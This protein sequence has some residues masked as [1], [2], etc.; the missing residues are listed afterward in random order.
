MKKTISLLMALLMVLSLLPTAWAANVDDMSSTAEVTQQEE[1]IPQ[2]DEQLPENEDIVPRTETPVIAPE[3]METEG[4]DDGVA[5]ASEDV[6]TALKNAGFVAA[7]KPEAGNANVAGAAWFNIPGMSEGLVTVSYEGSTEYCRHM[8]LTI[9]K[10]T[11]EQWQSLYRSLRQDGSYHSIWANVFFNAPSNATRGVKG[12]Y[13]ITPDNEYN[14]YT[15]SLLNDFTTDNLDEHMGSY[16]FSGANG[17]KCIGSGSQLVSVNLQDGKAILSAEAGEESYRDLIVW[18]NNSSADGRLHKYN[19]IITTKVE[20]DIHYEWTE[21]SVM[22]ELF[23]Q[24]YAAPVLGSDFGLDMP[25]G[26]VEDVDYRIDYN[27][28]TG[29]LNIQ[30]LPGEMSHWQQ[31]YQTLFE[32]HEANPDQY[33]DYFCTFM[34]FPNPSGNGNKVLMYPNDNGY[35]FSNFVKGNDYWPAAYDAPS[36]HYAG[37][38]TW[39]GD[40]WKDDDNYAHV[41][42]YEGIPY[43]Q[44]LVVS[45]ADKNYN[46]IPGKK[47]AVDIT[48]EVPEAFS[49]EWSSSTSELDQQLWAAGNFQAPDITTAETD[50]FGKFFIDM[51]AGMVKGSDYNYTY[52]NGVLTVTLFKGKQDH[53][54]AAY[55]DSIYN[56]ADDGLSFSILFNS[57]SGAKHCYQDVFTPTS[58]WD[59]LDDS[60]LKSMP[61][62]NVPDFTRF[63]NG[64]SLAYKETNGSN[65]TIYVNSG[66]EEYYYAVVW[67]DEDGNLTKYALKVIVRSDSDF[68]HTVPTLDMRSFNTTESRLGLDAFNDAWA[69]PIRKDG[70]LV[71]APASGKTWQDTKTGNI[72]VVAPVGYT[73]QSC[74]IDYFDDGNEKVCEQG[75]DGQYSFGVSVF[76]Q[77]AGGISRY[78][79]RWRSNGNNKPDLVETLTVRVDPQPLGKPSGGPGEPNAQDMQAI[80]EYLTEDKTPTGGRNTCD[81][82]FDGEVDVYDLQ[83]LYEA[84]SLGKG[85]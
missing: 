14:D 69:S 17:Y 30:L 60:K 67:E 85:F 84:V 57:V 78:V 56:D 62:S 50:D 6:D 48:I 53:W 12:S 35:S 19:F 25:D 46:P 61:S 16:D 83:R 3:V 36:D 55:L 74:Y 81:I 8:T 42:F 32:Q 41:A 76:D 26:L 1:T 43:S 72:N 31:A 40:A 24:G 29:V 66:R 65:T 71:L 51:P 23:D 64:F 10:G 82:N 4:E 44:Y 45:Y 75:I 38:S 34:G 20:A 73:L 5:V 49:Y 7:P 47:F 22:D 70:L 58:A 77:A 80:Y 68:S 13:Y 59:M 21:K 33:P 54:R 11:L 79:L 28:S 52:E 9:H 18:D 15:A 39:I 63:G 27:R 2:E 37:W